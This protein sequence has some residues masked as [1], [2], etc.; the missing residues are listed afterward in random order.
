[1]EV[2]NFV[3][4]YRSK[5][6]WIKII[7]I[8]D[9]HLGDKNC[10]YDYLKKLIKWIEEKDNRY[11]ILM[12]DLINFVA[13][14]DRRYDPD[15][16]DYRF[17][18]PESEYKEIRKLFTPLAEKGRIISCLEGNHEAVCKKHAIFDVTRNLA[19]DL[20]INYGGYCTF[21]RLQFRRLGREG[22]VNR[23]R[24]LILFAT[25][26]NGFGSRM[27][28]KINRVED[29]TRYIDASIYLHAHNH[30]LA[31]FPMVKLS[32]DSRGNIVQKKI[33]G[34]NTGCFLKS[35]EKGI[36]S[37]AERKGYGPSKVGVVKIMIR[38]ENLDIHASI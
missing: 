6:E 37:Y 18:T 22:Q 25:H 29:L 1:M 9:I 23:R 14:F 3:I 8:G 24:S 38:P 27:G 21:V 19:H 26:G 15:T 32:C 31:V 7:P 35:W 2:S 10:D 13:H 5:T 33:I 36:T 20:R 12:G 30:S 17:P 16:V 4:P 11:T 28:A 34:A